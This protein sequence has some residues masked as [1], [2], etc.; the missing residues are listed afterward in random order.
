MEEVDEEEVD[1]EEVD[2]G[3]WINQTNTWLRFPCETK[4]QQFHILTSIH[5]LTWVMYL[6]SSVQC[7]LH[8]TC[9]HGN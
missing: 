2:E 5:K 3:E 1:E 7:Q 4:S 9:F 6:T 8:Q